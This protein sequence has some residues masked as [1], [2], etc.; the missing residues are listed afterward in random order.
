MKRII[1]PYYLERSTNIKKSELSNITNDVLINLVYNL[2]KEEESL[3]SVICESMS[4]M[5]KQYAISM[6]PAI[7]YNVSMNE[8]IYGPLVIG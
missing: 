5:E 7:F 3:D 1:F 4:I 8:F 2:I 6:N